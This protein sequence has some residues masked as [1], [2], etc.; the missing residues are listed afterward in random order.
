MLVGKRNRAVFLLSSLPFGIGHEPDFL[1]LNGLL[2]NM[3]V[4][5]ALVGNGQMSASRRGVTLLDVDSLSSMLK[6]LKLGDVMSCE[7]LRFVQRADD[8]Y[9]MHMTMEDIP[10]IHEA[11]SLMKDHEYETACKLLKAVVRNVGYSTELMERMAVCYMNTQRLP[12]AISELRQVL[13]NSPLHYRSYLLLSNIYSMV[14]NM[15]LCGFP[16]GYDE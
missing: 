15:E 5:M 8:D 2:I 11:L 13:A 3:A 14:G 9:E 7:M 10:R 12:E 4:G 6:P 1:L 16:R